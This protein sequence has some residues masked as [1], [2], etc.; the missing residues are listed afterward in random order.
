M[1][2]HRKTHQ[3][4]S[5]TGNQMVS[6]FAFFEFPSVFIEE[7]VKMNIR[8]CQQ[9]LPRFPAIFGSRYAYVQYG[10]PCTQ[11]HFDTQGISLDVLTSQCGLQQALT[12][13]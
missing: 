4:I 8:V 7:L 10:S 12:L 11:D 6:W 9:M 2:L 3:V 13:R 5:Y 1:G